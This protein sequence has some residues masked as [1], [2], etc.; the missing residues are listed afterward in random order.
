MDSKE[1]DEWRDAANERFQ[2]AVEA[3]DF[4]LAKQI[5]GDTLEMGFIA[6]AEAMALMLRE[7]PNQEEEI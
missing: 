6:S 1:K 4:D 2:E 3:E 7:Y 5:I